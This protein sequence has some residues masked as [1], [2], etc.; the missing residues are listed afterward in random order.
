MQRESEIADLTDKIEELE[1]YRFVKGEE[2]EVERKLEAARSYEAVQ[3]GLQRAYS[4]VSGDDDGGV[5]AISLVRSAQ[6]SLAGINKFIADGE[7]LTERIKSLLIELEDIKGEIASNFNDDLSGENL[8]YLEERISDIL[9]MKRKY[10]CESDELPEKLECWKKRLLALQGGDEE[11]EK[12]LSEKRRLAEQVKEKALELSK[13]RKEAAERLERAITQQ[14]VFLDMPNVRL[15]YD[16]QQDK[17]KLTGMDT[18]Q[19]LISV[20]RGEE[21][22]PINKVASGGELSRIMLAIKNVLAENDEI[23][24]MIFD[25]IDTGISGRAAQKV[26]IKLAEIAEK[27]QVLCVTHLAQIAA[28]AD[29][30]LLIEKTSDEERTYT[31][32]HSLDFEARKKEI[33]RIISGDCDSELTLQNAE[34]LLLRKKQ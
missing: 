33:A 22:K 30:H 13:S 3:G 16:F 5:G 25:E 28:Q 31:N 32:I 20:N 4:A 19:M 34:E 7:Q 10:S 1:K 17:I 6:D 9:R 18:V 8:P 12:L 21:P 15:L 26:G 2:A 23:P 14:L 27:R 11:A 24:T 29:N